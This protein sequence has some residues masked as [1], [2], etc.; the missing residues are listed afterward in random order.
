MP[1]RSLDLLGRRPGHDILI[2]DECQVGVVMDAGYSHHGRRLQRHA[3]RFRD[4]TVPAR[5]TS[6]TKQS[7]DD[8]VVAGFVEST[9]HSGG[10]V[11]VATGRPTVSAGAELA[12]LAAPSRGR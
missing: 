11:L 6:I 9:P 5:R 4:K 10:L 1:D 3:A 7:E 2:D 12:F 8:H